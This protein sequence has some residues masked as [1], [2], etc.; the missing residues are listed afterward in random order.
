[1]NL[2]AKFRAATSRRRLDVQ[3]LGV[4][5]NHRIRFHRVPEREP[6]VA[7]ANLEDAGVPKIGHFVDRAQFHSS[8][9]QFE[10]HD[11]HPI[12]NNYPNPVPNWRA[13]LSWRDFMARPEF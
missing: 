6:P 2:R 9:V 3:F 8:G 12:T 10:C 1:M 7:G 11:T 13:T 5:S 4:N